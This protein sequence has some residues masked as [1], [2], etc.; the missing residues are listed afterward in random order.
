MCTVHRDTCGLVSWLHRFHHGVQRGS[1]KFP[2]HLPCHEHPDT[3]A[4]LRRE[5]GPGTREGFSGC[6]VETPR[7]R[8]PPPL[9]LS[10]LLS[11][12]AEPGQGR[13][14]EGP[15][16]GLQQW[17]RHLLLPERPHSCSG[18]RLRVAPGVFSQSSHYTPCNVTGSCL[19]SLRHC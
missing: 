16:L 5:S 17:T 6:R 10:T 1:G 11:A 8:P 15:H 18:S 4:G 7:S 9:Q 12:G 2:L 3:E 13:G 14:R 19:N